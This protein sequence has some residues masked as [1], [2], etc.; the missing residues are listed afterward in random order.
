[1]AAPPVAP[2]RVR[3]GDGAF[4]LVRLA[5][6]MSEAGIERAVA[7][8][9]GLAVGT[10]GLR[11]A[12]GVSGFHA[13]LAGDWEAVLLPERPQLPERPGAGDELLAAVRELG[14]AVRELGAT[15]VKSL[16]MLRGLQAAVAGVRQRQSPPREGDGGRVFAAGGSLPSSISASTE[17]SNAGAALL[18]AFEADGRPAGGSGGSGSSGGSGHRG[19]GGGGGPGL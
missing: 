3:Y 12:E 16:E 4:Q 13:G 14:A 10:F 7:L 1:M 11:D 2:F 8:A 9:T 15:S 18:P 17:G 5:P 19:G 6:G